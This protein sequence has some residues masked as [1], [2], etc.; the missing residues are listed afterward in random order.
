[1]STTSRLLRLDSGSLL[2]LSKL[3]EFTGGLP[4]GRIAAEAIARYALELTGT[5]PTCGGSRTDNPCPS[6]PPSP[7]EKTLAAPAKFPKR[8]RKVE[9]PDPEPAPEPVEPPLDKN[10]THKNQATEPEPELVRGPKCGRATL[11]CLAGTCQYCGPS[12]QKA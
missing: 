8:H 3:R 1:M 11:R 7:P 12:A 10:V 5:C 9:S 4:A 6:I 2:T